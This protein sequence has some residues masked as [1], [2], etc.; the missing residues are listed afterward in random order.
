MKKRVLAIIICAFMLL[1]FTLTSCGGNSSSGSGPEGSEAEQVS[2]PADESNEDS[3]PETSVEQSTEASVEQ[4]TE[5][6]AEESVEESSEELP[7]EPTSYLWLK[8]DG[9]TFPV[10]SFKVPGELLGEGE[11]EIEAVICLGS[12]RG[13]L[14]VDQITCLS[15]AS[16]DLADTHALIGKVN[17]ARETEF[18]AGDWRIIKYPFDPFQGDYEDYAE[19]TCTPAMLA[20]VFGCDADLG[21][22]KIAR[23]AI[24]QNDEEIWSVDFA[25]G[26]D[27][28]KLATNGSIN[29]SDSTKDTLWG[30]GEEIFT[31]YERGTIHYS[32]MVYV[33]PDFDEINALIAE[34]ESLMEK[35]EITPREMTDFFEVLTIK[36]VCAIGESTF[37]G[38]QGDCDTADEALQE[39][40]ELVTELLSDSKKSYF[41]FA[42]KLLDSEKYSARVFKDYT[43]EDKKEIRNAAESMDEEYVQLEKRLTELQNKYDDSDSIVV[44]VNGVELTLGEVADRFGSGEYNTAFNQA[45]GEIYLEILDIKKTIAKKYG[46]EDIVGYI[47]E[48][49]YSRDYSKEDIE[50]MYAY[51]KEFIVPLFNKQYANYSKFIYTAGDYNNIFLYE[52]IIKDY[53]KSINPKMLEAYNYLQEHGL[54]IYGSEDQKRGGAY[55]TIF[56]HHDEPIIFQHFDGSY[57]NIQTFIH[58]FGHFYEF[59]TYGGNGASQLDVDEIHSQAN[60]LLFLP[61]YTEIFGESAMKKITRYQLF[62]SMYTMIQSCV[63]SEFETRAFEGDYTSVEQLNL[64]FKEIVTSYNMTRFFSATIWSQVPH[65]FLYPHYYISYGTSVIPALQ[66]YA[67]SRE[68]RDEA[69]RVYNEVIAHSDNETPFLS[70]LEQSGL[71]DPF[72]RE[73]FEELYEMLVA[74]FPKG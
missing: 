55:T 54:Y 45:V 16:E 38:I 69:I 44:T 53:F 23:L 22:L 2:V 43:E 49:D 15:F 21:E 51:V 31:P 30:I 32:E 20:F 24:S 73:T 62:M 27:F 61:T 28:D 68:N 39:E 29:V 10:V 7:P 57:D 25:D 72:S 48:H 18:K 35:A 3:A 56:Y 13:I 64:L 11:I 17:Y 41:Q 36:L 63:L 34:G 66:I 65:L 4:S 26:L 58:E 12:D 67:I 50:N 8:A 59:Y 46:A 14:D 74:S 33:R 40:D 52:D 42:N 37:L 71:K 9:E 5:V 19:T 6:S 70:V 47:Y 60:E 1:T